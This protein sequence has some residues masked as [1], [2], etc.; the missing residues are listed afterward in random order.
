MAVH[1]CRDFVVGSTGSYGNL[2]ALGCFLQGVLGFT[3]VSA[4]GRAEFINNLLPVNVLTGSNAQY[5]GARMYAS[6]GFG[7]IDVPLQQMEVLPDDEVGSVFGIKRV[8]VGKPE[9]LNVLSAST[10]INAQ[11]FTL[12]PWGFTGSAVPPGTP[13]VTQSGGSYFVTSPNAGTRS[14][15]LNLPR[16][17]IDVDPVT[18]SVDAS[19][20]VGVVPDY[21]WNP[22]FGF[23]SLNV[24]TSSGQDVNSLPEGST[25]TGYV[26][27]VKSPAFPLANSGLYTVV[28][29]SYSPGF[30]AASSSVTGTWRIMFDA[31][32][33][34]SASVPF[35]D[36]TFTWS[37]FPPVETIRSGTFGG[38]ANKAYYYF[39][40]NPFTDTT[41]S[42]TMVASLVDN[43]P[44]DNL[45]GPPNDL[46]YH[47]Q[48]SSYMLRAIYQSPH[49]SGWQVRLAMESLYDRSRSCR[50]VGMS[51]APGFSGANGDFPARG[52]HLHAPMWWNS[53]DPTFRG[54]AVGLNPTLVGDTTI[55]TGNKGN[56]NQP[57]DDYR[58]RFFAWGDDSTG[59]VVVC[60]HNLTRSGDEFA[61]FGLP[62]D[63][64]RPLPSNTLQ[65]LF[66]VGQVSSSQGVD[67]RCGTATVDGIAGMAYSLNPFVGPVSCMMSSYAYAAN[68]LDNS[69]S[70]RFDAAAADTPFLGATELISVD[71]IAG[72]RDTHAT[73]AGAPVMNVEPRRLGRMPIARYGR[74]T[75]QP[76]WSTVDASRSWFHT[77]NGFYLPWGGVAPLP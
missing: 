50:G 56:T 19:G 54:T 53:T 70:I 72:A 68:Q 49:A 64:T 2:Y 3:Q 45:W 58:W 6:G 76:T 59:A 35:L 57:Q 75:G 20:H 37:V 69:S 12:G 65:R 34:D 46:Q 29:T 62:E 11:S 14:V 38:I 10:Y 7:F 77:M 36:T 24:I 18:A 13:Y 28:S 21:P 8:A 9:Y 26:L 22:P 63:E 30:T 40:W 32:T 17:R 60:N 55:Q 27:A 15:V 25:W 4:G 43:S 73:P 51:I 71:L 1:V 33:L 16:E 48:G 39:V 66:V 61:A 44:F 52:Q 31:R 23:E 74:A 67:W 41:G 5:P 47:T 42:R